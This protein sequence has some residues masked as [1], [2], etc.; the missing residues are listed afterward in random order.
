VPTAGEATAIERRLD[1]LARGLGA[2]ASGV[3]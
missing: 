1:A 3:P 2:S